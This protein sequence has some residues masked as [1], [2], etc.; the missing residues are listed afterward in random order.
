MYYAYIL[1]STKHPSQTYVGYSSDL[2]TR[3]KKHNEGDAEH[4]Q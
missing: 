2:K 4:F 3:L 1:R